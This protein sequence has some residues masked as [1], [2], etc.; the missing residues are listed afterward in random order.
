MKPTVRESK[1]AI[2]GQAHRRQRVTP[3]QPS[4]S[5]PRP[6]LNEMN[7]QLLHHQLEL[8]PMLAPSETPLS[9]STSSSAPAEDAP[10]TTLRNHPYQQ[11]RNLSPVTFALPPFRRRTTMSLR[12]I[13]T[14]SRQE[15][16]TGRSGWTSTSSTA[17]AVLQT[18]KSV[19]PVSTP[20]PPARVAYEA[21]QIPK[22]RF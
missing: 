3:P 6:S 7:H 9:P 19:P 12:T 10:A 18:E 1:F 5:S 22:T 13:K 11:D 21:I 14:L 8:S 2:V 16:W 15:N 17:S 4:P 20:I